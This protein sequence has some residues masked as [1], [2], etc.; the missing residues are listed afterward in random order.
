LFAVTG[1]AGFSWSD[2]V[3][4]VDAIVLFE[5]DVSG[6]IDVEVD[7]VGNLLIVV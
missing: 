2:F 4:V 5:G 1:K 6:V 7:V 3:V